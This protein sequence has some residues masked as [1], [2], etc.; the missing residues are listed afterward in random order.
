MA[1]LVATAV[2]LTYSFVNAV[3][4]VG[5]L[6]DCMRA[7]STCLHAAQR[8]VHRNVVAGLPGAVYLPQQVAAACEASALLSSAPAANASASAFAARVC[9]PP[10]LSY[11]RY[12]YIAYAA[13]FLLSSRHQVQHWV[14]GGA[15]GSG[16]R[17]SGG[18]R[19]RAAGA[20]ARPRRAAAVDRGG[21]A[22][23]AHRR[24]R[25]LLAG[26]PAGPVHHPA[27]GRRL[28]ALQQTG[29]LAVCLPPACAR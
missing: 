28:Q 22:A 3:H 29:A 14:C 15:G 8:W 12:V 27:R 1:A 21:A 19:Q 18:R 2:V 5:D 23:A 9:A 10:A 4:R 16:V 17:G 11:M 6:A 20:A 7:G 24:G 25:G 13:N 26:V